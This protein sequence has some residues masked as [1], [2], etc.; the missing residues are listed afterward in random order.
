MPAEPALDGVEEFLL[1]C[2]ATPAAWP[3][4][5][6]A[7][8]FHAAEGHSWRLTVDAD[9]ARPTRIPAPAAGQG[10]GPGPGP[11]GVSVRGAAGELVLFLYDRIPASALRV[12]G[13]AGLLDL[14]R[15][16]EPAE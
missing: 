4:R 7:F 13:D 15:A 16:W 6:T 9:G 5:P 14:L 2:C 10:P 12:D 11:A 1:T 3:H 8:D